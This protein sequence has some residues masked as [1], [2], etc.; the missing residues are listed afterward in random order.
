MVRL[1]AGRRTRELRLEVHRIKPLLTTNEASLMETIGLDAV[2][3]LRF[4][5]MGR[6]M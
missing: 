5:A 6:N 2:C 3:F 1:L 4:L